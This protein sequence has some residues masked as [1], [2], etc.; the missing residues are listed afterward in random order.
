MARFAFDEPAGVCIFDLDIEDDGIGGAPRSDFAEVEAIWDAG[1][2]PWKNGV[3]DLR[4]DIVDA[5]AFSRIAIDR[6]A[7]GDDLFGIDHAAIW[8]LW[9][10]RRARTRRP[11][12]IG[13]NV[14]FDVD[15]ERL[16]VFL[17]RHTVDRGEVA[18]IVA[19]RIAIAW[20]D[21]IENDIRVIFDASRRETSDESQ[22]GNDS[23]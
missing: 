10:E 6:F 17:L 15:G 21:A 3:I 4:S 7:L 5:F 1:A 2:T 19:R 8:G 18:L 12:G 14:V 22:G 11:T 9:L 13:R 16:D 20:H 23:P